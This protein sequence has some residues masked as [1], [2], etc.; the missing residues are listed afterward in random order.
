MTTITT[1]EEAQRLNAG[2]LLTVRDRRGYEIPHVVTATGTQSN[3]I[4]VPWSVFSE[5]IEAAASVQVGIEPRLGDLLVHTGGRYVD[6][7]VDLMPEDA[8]HARVTRF[9]EGV[10]T[11]ELIVNVSSYPYNNFSIIEEGSRDT[12]QNLMAWSARALWEQTRALNDLQGQARGTDVEALRQQVDILQGQVDAAR[13]QRETMR[14]QVHDALAEHIEAES[15]DEGEYDALDRAFARLGGWPQSPEIETWVDLRVRVTGRRS[16]GSRVVPTSDFVRDSLEYNI[17]LDSDWEDV[18]T[19]V[20]V[21]SVSEP[22]T[23]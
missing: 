14:S 10:R 19:D 4:E 5:V 18:S 15:I 8:I 1:L 23:I 11:G 6:V 22:E 16:N 21:T 7:I 3:G 20:E 12:A 13:E 2:T 9:R 17:T